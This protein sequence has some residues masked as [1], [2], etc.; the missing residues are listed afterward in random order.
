MTVATDRN[1]FVDCGLIAN[2]DC[3]VTEDRHFNI[4]KTKPFPTISVMKAD[5][6]LVWVAELRL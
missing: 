2:A 1:K 4:L 5:E 6:F 3:I